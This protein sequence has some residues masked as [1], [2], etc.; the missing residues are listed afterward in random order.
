MANFFVLFA[1]IFKRK[2]GNYHKH[3]KWS[4]LARRLQER[5]IE[6]VMSR[7]GSRLDIAV[8]NIA[9]DIYGGVLPKNGEFLWR[10]YPDIRM[11]C[12]SE[13]KIL[14]KRLSRYDIYLDWYSGETWLVPFRYSMPADKF[15]IYLKGS[16]DTGQKY[17]LNVLREWS[18]MDDDEIEQTYKKL[19]LLMREEL[20]CD[21]RDLS[22]L[23]YVR[24]N[25]NLCMGAVV[26]ADLL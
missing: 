12:E 19:V 17:V 6:E 7:K 25:V 20:I 2:K 14:I 15:L 5:G 24:V 21:H 3:K 26:R 16:V 18:G 22:S 10:E 9:K 13:L 11:Q 1:R 4:D 23:L 8:R